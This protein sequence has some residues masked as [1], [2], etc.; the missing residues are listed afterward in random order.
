MHAM[1]WEHEI[2]H[3][4]RTLGV[5]PSH[6]PEHRSFYNGIFTEKW[7]FR[8]TPHSAF[9]FLVLKKLILCKY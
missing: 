1:T 5:V 9:E 8:K 7:H 2:K 6:F 4:L 3:R